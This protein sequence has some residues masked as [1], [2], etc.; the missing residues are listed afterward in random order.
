M[1]SRNLA[2][3]QQKSVPRP[4]RTSCTRPASECKLRPYV[5]PCVT[6]VSAWSS[7]SGATPTMLSNVSPHT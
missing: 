4:T 7:A 6:A 2:L 1:V 5:V 3:V